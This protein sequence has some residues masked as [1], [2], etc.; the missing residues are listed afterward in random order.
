MGPKPKNSAGNAKKGDVAAAEHSDDDPDYRPP[1]KN[2]NVSEDEEDDVTA[3]DQEEPPAAEGSRKRKRLVKVGPDGAPLQPSKA[4]K[5]RKKAK[6][7]SAAGSAPAVE[8]IEIES[9]DEPTTKG[10]KRGPKTNTRLHFHPPIAVQYKG[11]KRWEFRCRHC[12]R[13]CTFKRTVNRDST[14]DDEPSQPNLGNLATH[15]NEHGGGDIP[16]PGKQNLPLTRGV[17]AASAKIMEQF[18]IDGQLNPTIVPT[19]K[20]ILTIFS[21]WLLEND[22]P[23]T[24]G[25]TP[26]IQRLFKYLKCKF[27][28]PSDTT[29]RNTLAPI[30]SEML[31]KLKADLKMVK[32]KIA[33]STDTWTTR[34][35]M[36]TFCG[37]IGSWITEDWELVERVLDFHAIED[38]EHEGLYA[39]IGMATRL[40]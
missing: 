16:V 33:V 27:L 7:S 24:T 9:D 1:K 20:G 28:L 36:F 17:S 30:F 32:S 37:T 12:P 13:S 14:F 38:K 8:V 35:M 15:L 40:S 3:S 29:V 25:E 10:I 22:L 19:Q 4:R 11:Q 31:D 34:S 23:F 2:R 39:A 26:G 5:A 18:L 21:A 6:K